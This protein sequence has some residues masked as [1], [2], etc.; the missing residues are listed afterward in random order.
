[1]SKTDVMGILATATKDKKNVSL[2][3]CL[4]CGQKCCRNVSIEMDLPQAR[5]DFDTFLW[6]LAHKNIVV[7]VDNGVWHVEF[8]S[9][10]EKLGPDGKCS[11]YDTRPQICRDYGMGMGESISCEGFSEHQESCDQYFSSLEELE[12]FIPEHLASLRP[13]N[14]WEWAKEQL[15]KTKSFF[16]KIN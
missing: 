15:F 1:M 14:S 13:A 8:K 9:D 5:A 10:C 2:M 11:I 12:Q 3:D 7:Y 6:L 16:R 4:S